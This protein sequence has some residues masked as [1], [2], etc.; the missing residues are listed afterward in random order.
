P[1][2]KTVAVIIGAPYEGGVGFKP[3]EVVLIALRSR[4]RERAR[5]LNDATKLAWLRRPDTG[6]SL[7]AEV[8]RPSQAI[9]RYDLRRNRVFPTKLLG[10]ECAPDGKYYWLTPL[11][12]DRAGLCNPRERG[13]RC[14]RAFTWNNEP[15]EL[16]QDRRIQRGLVWAAKS[17]HNMVFMTGSGKSREGAVV[18]LGTGEM[19]PISGRIDPTWTPRDGWLVM[20]TDQGPGRLRRLRK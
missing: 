20:W 16:P 12:S 5:G 9:V 2:D 8:N 3:E 11:E 7:F 13:E 18:D 14:L 10:L 15:I 4:G 17:G 6:L 19:K 1:D